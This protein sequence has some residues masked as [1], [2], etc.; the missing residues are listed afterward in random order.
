MR[1]CQENHEPCRRL[2]TNPMPKRILEISTES[3]YLREATSN[4][5]KY[6]CL[7]HCWG[8]GGPTITLTKAT[9]S[10]LS[11]GYA[12]SEMPKTFRDAV[13]VCQ[14]LGISCLW[15][16][17]LCESDNINTLLGKSSDQ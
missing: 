2:V 7:S 12:V 16:D 11:Q 10:S 1:N 15:I 13:V 4:S 3:V 8:T 9:M 5:A 17:A 14:S 6:A